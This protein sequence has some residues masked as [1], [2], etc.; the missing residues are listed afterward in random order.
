MY[1]RNL[2]RSLTGGTIGIAGRRGPVAMTAC[3]GRQ[4]FRVAV[5]IT[6]SLSVLIAAENSK[7]IFGGPYR[8]NH[9]SRP[10]SRL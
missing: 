4:F 1:R 8:S 5:V 7:E 10:S 6:V 2:E 9:D 3:S